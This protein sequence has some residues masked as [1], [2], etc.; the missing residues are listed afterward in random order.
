M[1]NTE[2]TKHVA[3]KEEGSKKDWVVQ[4]WNAKKEEADKWLTDFTITI[5]T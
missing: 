2:T 3:Q 4:T 5:L 1:K